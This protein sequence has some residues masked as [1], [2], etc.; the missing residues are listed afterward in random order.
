MT[1]KISYADLTYTKQGIS[2]MSFPLGVAKVASCAKRE[3]EGKIDVEVFKYPEDLANYLKKENPMI[4]CFSN[5]SWTLDISHEFAK[6]IKENSPQTITVFGGPNFPL[7][8]NEQKI[9]LKEHQGIDFYIMGEGEKSFV[10]LYKNLEQFDFDAK[11]FKENSMESGNCVYMHNQKIMIG[12]DLTRLKD[13]DEVPSPYLSGLMDKFFDGTLTPLIQTTR[14]CP[15]KCSY[16]QEGQ[17]YFNRISRHS[18]ENIKN[19]LE[20]IAERISVPNLIITDS[21]FGMFKQDIKTAEQIALIKK[22]TGWPK[23][24]NT[25]LGKNEKAVVDVTSK[26]KG[27][28]LLSAPVQSTDKR[29]LENIHRK[30]ISLDQIIA[31]TKSGEKH[32]SNNLSEVILCL[33]GDTKEAHFKSMFDMIDAEINVVRSHQLL[34]LPGSEL[35]TAKSREKYNMDTRFRLQ[36]KCFGDYEVYGESFSSAEIDELCVANSTMNYE[37]YLKCRSLDLT[38]E[39]FYNDGVFKGL[40][41]FIKQ[42]E[43]PTSLFIE[44]INKKTSESKLKDVYDGFLRETKESL[45][46]SK[47]EL[48]EHIKHPGMMDRYIKEQ[49]RNNEQHKYRAIAFFDKMEELH[50]IAF[51]SSKELL[52]QRGKLDNSTSQYLGELFNFNLL[53]KGNLLS[54]ENKEREFNYDFICLSKEGF[55]NNPLKSKRKT[56]IKFYHTPKQKQTFSKYRK[57]FGSSI[58]SLGAILSI[59]HADAKGFYRK[60]KRI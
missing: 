55:E 22:R 7:E 21:N 29:V 20:Y 17:P 43:I 6:K 2:N 10:E 14:G 50:K 30:N 39:L 5:Y 9:F 33:P 34:M 12:E 32:G 1:N 58:D 56:N 54:F 42:K 28:I 37:D 26:L 60:V 23:Y 35:S 25:S 19:E 31:V 3:L 15:F 48:E 52:K 24:I 13:L 38:V 57:Q 47:S 36:P 40:I 16:C 11:S 45:W 8:I 59:S 41:K 44:S 27:G 49:I 46:K 51:D 4:A 18:K 53:R